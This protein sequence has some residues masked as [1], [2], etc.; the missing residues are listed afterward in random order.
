MCC[1]DSCL[2][3]TC[4]VLKWPLTSHIAVLSNV[5]ID[6]GNELPVQIP[7]AVRE[8]TACLMRHASVGADCV[9]W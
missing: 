8:S 4:Q 7:D 2:L 3:N 9:W 1:P 6:L 5:N